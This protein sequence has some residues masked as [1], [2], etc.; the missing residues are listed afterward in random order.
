MP[1]ATGCS[2]GAALA[3]TAD[4]KGVRVG[5][6]ENAKETREAASRP[7][8]EDLRR[9]HRQ[10]PPGLGAQPHT[11]GHMHTVGS[12]RA[13]TCIGEM[14]PSGP[15]PACTAPWLSLQGQRASDESWNRN[16]TQKTERHAPAVFSQNPAF[17]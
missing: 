11:E 16:K 14:L 2:R 6:A 3:D 15:A 17:C 9:Q 12:V 7:S 10:V 8:R 5:E 13:C 1:R 4:L